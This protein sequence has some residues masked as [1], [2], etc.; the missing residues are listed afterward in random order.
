MRVFKNKPAPGD[1]V[2][3]LFRSPKNFL[4]CAENIMHPIDF[5]CPLPDELIVTLSRVL[6]LGPAGVIAHRAGRA[7]E[8][9]GLLKSMEAD[10]A[11]FLDS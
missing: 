7:K 4:A 11:A 2:F 9:V 1:L 10:N 3:G 8:L 5:S 6:Q